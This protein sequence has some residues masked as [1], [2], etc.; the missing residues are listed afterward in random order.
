MNTE[1]LRRPFL[2]GAGL[3][4][5]TAA[6]SALPLPAAAATWP[7]TLSVAVNDTVRGATEDVVFSGQLIVT[8]NVIIDTS[9][10][11]PR[12]LELIVDFA[13]V[14]GT[15]VTTGDKYVTA[16]QSILHRPLKTLDPIQITFPFYNDAQLAAARTALAT[17]A[18]SYLPASGISVTS[19][20][21][22]PVF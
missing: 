18:V 22:T 21:T 13:Q 20:L 12:V 2:R 15:G 3:A 4:A 14:V 19:K 6:I 1:S 10:A 9:L 11:G 8:S 5:L 16:A 7:Q 17:L